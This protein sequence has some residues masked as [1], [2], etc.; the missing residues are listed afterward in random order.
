VSSVEMLA[1]QTRV[2][3]AV[4]VGHEVT[5]APRWLIVSSVAATGRLVCRVGCREPTRCCL[6]LTLFQRPLCEEKET[7]S[8]TRNVPKSRDV[9][10]QLGS[11]RVLDAIH[12]LI[13]T[14]SVTVL[15]LSILRFG[16]Q[17]LRPWLE[18]RLLRVAIKRTWSFEACGGLL[19]NPCPT[20]S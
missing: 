5:L 12:Q 16:S 20:G 6:S 17:P 18:K 19:P 7:L 2:R 14:T 1:A 10:T 9:Q 4:G 15:L 11:R 13:P 8:V 3:S